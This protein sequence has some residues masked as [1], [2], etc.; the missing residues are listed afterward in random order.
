MT[1]ISTYIEHVFKRY[2]S[3]I[4]KENAYRGVI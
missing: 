3:G 1:R 2:R 4:A